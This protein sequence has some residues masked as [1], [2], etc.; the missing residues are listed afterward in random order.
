LFAS[1]FDDIKDA[2][3]T[4]PPIGEARAYID[5]S[6]MPNFS[7]TASVIIINTIEPRFD[8]NS[9]KSKIFTSLIALMTRNKEYGSTMNGPISK[10]KRAIVNKIV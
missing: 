6:P 5:F 2:E 10:K 1:R 4:A 7:C 8:A 3:M 9:I